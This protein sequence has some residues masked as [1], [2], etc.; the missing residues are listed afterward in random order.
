MPNLG[1]LNSPLSLY[2]PVKFLGQGGFGFVVLAMN[3]LTGEAVAIK[4]AE[5]RTEASRKIISR[6]V[7]NHLTLRHPHVV[8]LREVLVATPYVGIVM[9]Y[10]SGGTLFDYVSGKGGLTEAEARWFFQQLLIGLDY[11]HRKGV[12]SRDIKLQNTLLAPQQTGL[13]PMVKICDFGYSKHE[14]LDSIAKTCVG[15]PAYIAPEVLSSRQAYDGKKA[16]VWSTGIML[17]AMLFCRYPF[18]SAEDSSLG[19]AERGQ[20]MMKRIVK[21]HWSFPPA[22]KLTPSCQDLLRQLLTVDSSRR[23]SLQEVM[24]HPWFQEGLPP[25]SLS[26]NETALRCNL[27]PNQPPQQAQQAVDMV[28]RANLAS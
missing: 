26:Y 18:D 16:D 24:E 28:F 2:Q 9:E 27:P 14:E 17:Y 5:C 8:E 21:G 4:F 23:A 3:K 1:L 15:T 10:V 22:P 7:A 11:C 6:E 19:S 13:P 20:R 12:V 25:N